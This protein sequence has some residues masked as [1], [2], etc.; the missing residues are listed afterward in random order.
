LGR[1]GEHPGRSSKGLPGVHPCNLAHGAYDRSPP[2]WGAEHWGGE[3]GSKGLRGG[4]PDGP[5][6]GAW[7]V[8]YPPSVGSKIRGIFTNPPAFPAELRGQ[9][10]KLQQ[11]RRN[12]RGRG[13]C[14]I[15]NEG[16]C[17]PGVIRRLQIFSQKMHPAIQ[18]GPIA[19]RGGRALGGARYVKLQKKPFRR[20]N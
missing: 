10:S 18:R 20:K 5:C 8:R 11:N 2:G 3:S 14:Y 12:S 1:T 19:P 15:P 7:G 16:I 9:T 6:I 13:G 17:T 4:P